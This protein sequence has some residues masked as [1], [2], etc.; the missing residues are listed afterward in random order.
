MKATSEHLILTGA[1]TRVEFGLYSVDLMFLL[2]EEEKKK[3]KASQV[4]TAICI[5]VK[6]I[7]QLAGQ[8][9]NSPLGNYVRAVSVNVIPERE[10]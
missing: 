9:G 2:V 4:K 6:L 10:N 5:R 3:K 1:Y 7:L 8:K